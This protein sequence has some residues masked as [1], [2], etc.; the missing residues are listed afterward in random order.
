ME[1]KRVTEVYCSFVNNIPEEKK[2]RFKSAL[3]DA[4]DDRY[5]ELIRC[6]WGHIWAGGLMRL[7]VVSIKLLLRDVDCSDKVIN[8]FDGSIAF[9]AVLLFLADLDSVNE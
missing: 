8:D 1:E 7:P 4:A 9:S 6:S 2:L 5:D 3:E